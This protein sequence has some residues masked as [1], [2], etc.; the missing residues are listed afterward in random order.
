[1]KGN[2]KKAILIILAAVLLPGCRIYD[3]EEVLLQREDISLTI[4]GEEV[5]VY[6]EDTFQL[7][8]SSEKN[9]FRVFDDNLANWFVL[10]CSARPS[11]EGQ[12][13]KADLSWTSPNTTKTRKGLTFTVEKTGPEGFL[14]LW[15]ETEAA[16]VV[17]REL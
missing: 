11:T 13:V 7:G 8:Y 9:E 5:L 4:R 15:C 16:G 14:W 2:M 1:M 10:R 3:I 12:E 17:V 6:D